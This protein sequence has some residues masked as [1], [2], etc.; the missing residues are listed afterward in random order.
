MR[1]L[2]IGGTRLVGRGIASAAITAGHDVT[3]FNR[4]QY[5]PDGLPGATLLTGDRNTDLSALAAGEWDATVD[6]CAYTARQVRALHE[7]LGT[8]GG[9]FTFVSTISVYAED[10]PESG[11]TE[12]APLLPADHSDELTME[13]YGELKVA[14]EE[15]AAELFDPLLI[16]RPGYVIGPYDYTER[17]THW[18]REV[19]GG[20]PITA[21]AADQPL[22]TVDGRDLGAFTV[23]CIEAGLTGAFNVTAPQDPP[24]FREVLDTIAGALGVPLPDVTWGDPDSESEELPLS[25]GRSWWPMMRADLSK[26]TDAGLRWRPLADTVKDTADWA[27]I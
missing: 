15:V 18:I 9:H 16:I 24:T 8:R 11:F 19:A 6:V 7:A 17:F 22:Q 26:A 13:K 21:P 14:C 10:V 1:I 23:Q 2:I 3:L 5:E 27:G 4:G 25:A 20:K 12:D